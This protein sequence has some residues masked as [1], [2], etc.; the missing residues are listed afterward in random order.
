M[1][2]R[3]AG[4]KLHCNFY[5]FGCVIGNLLDLDLAV[6]VCLYDR[7]HQLCSGYSIRHVTDQDGLFI[8]LL[9][10]GAASDLTTAFTIIICI[11]INHTAGLE[12]RIEFKLL[13]Q[14]MFD[15]C[16]DELTEIMWQD[17]G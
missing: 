15:G 6:V 11:G 17:L 8:K 7:I 3:N 12:I 5:L 2:R 14:Q 10:M 4:S 9:N 13:P 16:I 1:I